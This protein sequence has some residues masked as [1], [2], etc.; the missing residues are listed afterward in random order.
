[1]SCVPSSKCIFTP[2]VFCCVEVGVI[3]LGVCRL[4]LEARREEE[5]QPKN[6]RY[7]SLKFKLEEVLTRLRDLDRLFLQEKIGFKE[8]L[9]K[10]KGIIDLDE[11]VG[12]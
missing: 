9:Q 1:M 4:C 12:I 2:N 11:S 6:T 5:T 10:R 3:T 7:T 8:Y